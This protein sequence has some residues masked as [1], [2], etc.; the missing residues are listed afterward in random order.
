MLLMALLVPWAA[1]AQTVTI[2]TGTSAQNS[3]PIANYYNYSMAEMIFTADEID[4]IDVN[5]ILSLGFQCTT[6][7]SKNYGVTVYMK[8]IEADAFTATTDFI[9]L[10]ATDVVFTGTVSPT[11]GWTTIDLPTPFT[12]NRT[13]NLLIAVNKT[14][15]GYDG[16]TSIWNYTS[17]SSYKMLYAQ[18][19]S[20]PGVYDPTTALSLSLN[21]NRPNVQLVFGTPPS[22][23]KP[24]GLTVSGV[25]HN[26][27]TLSWTENGTATS[28]Q[29]C[30]NGD[31][32]HPVTM[33]TNPYTLTGLTTLTSYTVKVRPSCDESLWSSEISFTTLASCPAPQDVE[34]SNI[35]HTTADV[36]W[37]GFS[38]SY[39][40]IYRVA[41]TLSDPPIFSEDFSNGIGG[42]TMSNCNS[43]TGVSGENFRFHWSTTPPQYLISPEITGIDEE[44]ILEFKY[45]DYG[46]VES[47]Q[48]GY[49][50]TTAEVAS[51]TFG[52][53]INTE[54]DTEVETYHGTVPAGTK[55]ISIKCTSNNQYYLYIDDIVI[56][57][58]VIIPWITIEDATNP[59]PLTPLTP[60]INY[61]VKVQGVCSGI[62][63]QESAV[64]TFTTMSANHKL[65]LTEGDWNVDANWAPTGAPTIEQDVELRANVTIT[66]EAFANSIT[67]S[68]YSVTIEDGAKL[69]HLSGNVYAT[70]KKEIEGY[71]NYTGEDNGGYYLI[72]NPL[73]SS[74]TPNDD[75]NHILS[76]NYDLYSFD[77]SQDL[78]WQNYRTETFPL[79]SEAYGYLY[80]NETGTTLTYT[81]NI[82][83]YTGSMYQYLISSTST[84]QDFPGWYLLGNPYMYDAYFANYYSTALP[85]IKMN[86]A[87]DGFENVAAG[88]PIAPMEGFFYQ[89]TSTGGVYVTTSV[90]TVQSKG[91]LNMNLRK[92]NKQLDNAILVFG[93][94]QQLGKFSFRESSSK[95]YMPVEGKDLA[96]TSVEGQVGE[97]PI[98]FKAEHNGNYTLNFT[99]QE[100]SFSYLHLI[101]NLTGN[102]VDLLETP[103]YSFDAQTTDYASRFRLVFATGSSVDGDSFGFVNG[104]GNLCIFGIEGE[105]TI[106]VIDILGHMVSSD[107]FSG[108]YE[109]KLNVAP[110]VYMIRLINGND[111]KVQK[112]VVR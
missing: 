26:E 87:G 5:T 70:V 53:E 96:I 11:S 38:T 93:G 105:S 16:Y 12:Y 106:Q 56:A 35:M 2:G 13:G 30:L 44:A 46:W 80:A 88:T 29:Y 89:A 90:P 18:N 22:T 7:V 67:Q 23:P 28:W 79:L 94:E 21:Y 41:P 24:T 58:P 6:N 8:N 82:Q 60:G 107:T 76:G 81:G 42:W 50:T 103:S 104:M 110:G 27:A 20:N 101:D 62:P 74:V 72:T 78:E 39:N 102:D 19:D 71:T 98:S 40:V 63:G 97:Q 109:R 31:E 49:S 91:Q 73:K 68:T 15:G 69:K 95:I 14:S 1:N 83:T 45:W 9:T 54:G 10:S 65:F 43:S 99:S 32:D 77:Y 100:V 75:I 47:F 51:F 34:V 112:I 48:V 3:A 111:V 55:Y 25:T 66:G 64:K 61:E 33:N 4:T 57:E 37:T 59:Q 85:Y 17:T 36:S 86:A 84:T 108:S 52:S 92:D